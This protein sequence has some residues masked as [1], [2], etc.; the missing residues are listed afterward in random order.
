MTTVQEK[1]ADRP[2]ITD[3]MFGNKRAI[4]I[5]AFMR[6]TCNGRSYEVKNVYVSWYPPSGGYTSVCTIPQV[7]INVGD[8][9]FPGQGTAPAWFT[10]GPNIEWD[11]SCL[12]EGMKVCN[13]YSIEGVIQD[14]LP[15]RTCFVQHPDGSIKSYRECDLVKL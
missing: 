15:N 7:R 1:Y 5:Y 2:D 14:I 9:Y 3:V 12:G 8:C 6:F 13:A 11:E 4:D 10:A